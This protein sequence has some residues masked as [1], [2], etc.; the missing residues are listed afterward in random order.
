MICFRV[1]GSRPERVQSQKERYFQGL[2]LGLGSSI[3]LAGGQQL[4]WSVGE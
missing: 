2:E 3:A 4:L 1:N